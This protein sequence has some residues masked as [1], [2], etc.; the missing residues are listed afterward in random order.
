MSNFFPT[1]EQLQALRSA[2]YVA[3]SPLA[4]QLILLLGVVLVAAQ[5]AVWSGILE[6]F[7]VGFE[8]N[9]SK[10]YMALFECVFSNSKDIFAQLFVLTFGL[11]G[12]LLAGSILGW[13]I[14]TRCFFSFKKGE[15]PVSE[16]RGLKAM[17][18]IFLL[19]IVCIAL[20][21]VAVRAIAVTLQSLAVP[22]VEFSF[23]HWLAFLSSLSHTVALVAF[24][25]F[26]IVYTGV[27][28][29]FIW[30]TRSVA[31]EGGTAQDQIRRVSF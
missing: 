25:G 1:K 20:Y 5:P 28:L 15:S 31:S 12:L 13:A 17:L 3:Y 2:G 18:A 14:Q 30:S 7:S 29:F 4:T 9:M 24:L 23:S 27:F 11:I 6:S 26:L 21:Q 19:P 10:P 22:F 8:C 16:G